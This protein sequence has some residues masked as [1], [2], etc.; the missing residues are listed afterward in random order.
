MSTT[1]QQRSTALHDGSEVQDDAAILAVASLVR[2]EVL[3]GCTSEGLCFEVCSQLIVTLGAY[4]IDCSMVETNL[5][6]C[7]WS[8][9]L[10]HFWIRLADGRAL[11]PTADQFGFESEVYLG[12]PDWPHIDTTGADIMQ[13]DSAGTDEGWT[14]PH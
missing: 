9:W 14:P 13:G 8:E 12:A 7:I 3:G 11:D 5:E 6:D 2:R 4:G 1:G 10:N